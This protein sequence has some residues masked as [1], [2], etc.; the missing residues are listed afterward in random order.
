[1][2]TTSL[3]IVPRDFFFLQ[4]KANVASS[5][6]YHKMHFRDVLKTAKKCWHKCVISEGDYF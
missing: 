6:I 5:R 3:G 2:A 1:M 4:K